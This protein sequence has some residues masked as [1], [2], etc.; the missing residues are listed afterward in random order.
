MT[1]SLARWNLRNLGAALFIAFVFQS[2]LL[3]CLCP[4]GTAKITLA[5]CFD[6]LVLL[7]MM[8]AHLRSETGRGWLFYAVL[9]YTSV[10][11]IEG[12]TYLVLGEV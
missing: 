7:R 4:I 10:A 5:Y 8:I 9:C 3:P 1:G 11:W 2:L 12:I 6:C